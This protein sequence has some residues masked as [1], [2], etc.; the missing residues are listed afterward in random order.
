MAKDRDLV[1]GALRGDQGAF[2]RLLNRY[3]R[4]VVHIVH[5]MI[6]NESD[7]EDAYQE[8][9]MKVYEALPR[10]RLEAKL[11]TWIGKIAYNTCIN[12]LNKKRELLFDDLLPDDR[13]VDSLL[14]NHSRPDNQVEGADLAKRVE[15]EI[16]IMPVQFR[17][18]L[19]LYH[20]ESMSY[21]EI[22]EVINLPEG[23]VKSYLFR[24]RKLLKHRLLAKYGE[25]ELRP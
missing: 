6:A 21:R 17:T 15:A 12:H 8:V 23:T 4:L 11:S 25:E 16:K 13:P 20:L 18:I 14:K 22:G 10:F 5:R 7:A 2:E 3:K 9:F 19:T 1:E 24:A